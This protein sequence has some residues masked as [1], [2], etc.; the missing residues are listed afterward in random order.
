M[1]IIIVGAGFTGIQLAK[2]LIQD[3]NDVILIESDEETVRHASNRLDCMVMQANGNSLVTLEEAGISKADAIVA[4]TDSDEVNMITCSLV[5]SVYPQITKIARVRNYDYYAE[6][7]AAGSKTQAENHGHLYGIDFMVHPDVE[8]ADAIVG[9]VEHGALSEVMDFEDSDFELTQITVEPDSSFAG[10]PIQNIRTLTQVPFLV[11]FIEK[12][13]V[14]SLPSG[15]TVLEAGDRIGIL[16]K[17]DCV[18]EFIRLCGSEMQTFRKIAL[19]GAGRIGTCI[20]EK[21]LKEKKSSLFKRLFGIQQ[22]L[23]QEFLIIEPDEKQAAIAAE[24]FPSASICHADITDEGIIEEENIASFDLVIA[25]TR[26]HE[27]N[28]IASSYL[29]SLGVKKTV[30]LVTSSGY[31][32][33]SRN[34]GI[35]VA[36]PIRDAVIDS[37][38]SHLRGTSVTG[39]HTV[40][41]GD[42]EILEIELP[43]NAPVRGKCLKDIAEAGAFLILLCKSP[44][45]ANFS[46]PG[47]N[48]VLEAGDKLILIVYTEEN[49]RVLQKFGIT[50]KTVSAETSA[51]TN[52]TE[53]SLAAAPAAD[54]S[55]SE[56]SL[57]DISGHI[58]KVIDKGSSLFEKR[59]GNH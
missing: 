29:K 31:A 30:C 43:E 28:M 19:L 27:K 32:G 44:E 25:A 22:K 38:L 35:D 50:D 13:G 9:A 40:S 15:P 36:V 37:I 14:A 45:E 24:K 26:N 58:G 41:D 48:T 52:A 17:R 56:K 53:T 18:A 39:I 42:L 6:A 20:A 7:V 46:V 34:I 49:M 33:I 2:R 5:N 1:K 51:S 54:S 3:K 59:G 12:A 47:G 10:V 8:A 55:P 21:L 4:V 23:Q 11:A 57:P 16:T